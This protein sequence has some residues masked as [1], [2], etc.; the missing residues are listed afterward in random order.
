MDDNTAFVLLALIFAVAAVLAIWALRKP[1]GRFISE[2][3]DDDV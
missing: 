2:E 3:N 1:I